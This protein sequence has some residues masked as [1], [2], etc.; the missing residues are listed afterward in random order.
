M[1]LKKP[2]I[3]FLGIL[4]VIAGLA[5]HFLFRIENFLKFRSIYAPCEKPIAYALG[6]FDAKFG[7][8]KETFLS[9]IKEAEA[10]WEKPVGKELF[11]YT[12]SGNE[13]LKVNLVYDYRQQATGVLKNL[14]I[15]VKEDRTSYDQ[16]KAKYDAFNKEYLGVKAEYDARL[17][18]FTERRNAYDREVDYW[19]KQGGAPERDYKKLQEEKTALQ[20]ELAE[21]QKLE[22][23]LNDYTNDINSLAVVLNRLAVSLNLN[24]ENYNEVGASRGEEFT[25]GDYQENGAGR[26]I[27]I[28]E[29][30]SRDKLVRLLAH[31]LG[32]ALGLPHVED[33]KAIMYELN[34]SMNEKLTSD[35]IKALKAR[36]AIN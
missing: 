24:V 11:V 35:D 12:S 36:C 16:L 13:K 10:V 15:V 3:I 5:V 4:A 7:L 20:A 19:N 28:Y 17:I 18:P 29:F 8:S 2:P 26:K 9:A 6:T 34:T 14:G 1:K 27:N 31:E 21:I 30:S 25:E 23:K 33:P 32:H 22:V